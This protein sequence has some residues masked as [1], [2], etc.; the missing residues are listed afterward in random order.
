MLKSDNGLSRRIYIQNIVMQGSVWGSLFC[1]TTMDK[2]GQ[3]S[4]KDENMIYKY[5]GLVAVPSICMVDDIMSIQKCSDS[6]K[7]NAVIN[8]FIEMK[9]LRLSHKKCSRI[10]IGK[11]TIECPEL[12]VHEHRMKNSSQEKYLGDLLDQSGSIKPTI[13]DRVSK[14][15]GYYQ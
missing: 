2:L 11:H 15:W 6:G 9:K 14:A 8:A 7:T 4:Y 3:I 1:T 12:K 5:K 10:H 13:Q